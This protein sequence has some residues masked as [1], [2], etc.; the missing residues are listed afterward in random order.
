MRTYCDIF[1]GNQNDDMFFD[2]VIMDEASK[3]TLEMAV[4]LVL[5]KK[6]III[7]D[8]KQL[9]PMLDENTIDSSLER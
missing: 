4:P 2:V 3:A 5:G 6:I 7:G 8:H 9:P 1:G